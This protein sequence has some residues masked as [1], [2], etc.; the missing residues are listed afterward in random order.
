MLRETLQALEK[1]AIAWRQEIFE[2][3]LDAFLRPK[4]HQKW[5]NAMRSKSMLAG[6]MAAR[7]KTIREEHWGSPKIAPDSLREGKLGI[8]KEYLAK[9]PLGETMRLPFETAKDSGLK[10]VNSAGNHDIKQKD[11]LDIFDILVVPEKDGETRLPITFSCGSIKIK[12]KLPRGTELLCGD[13]I[14]L[15]YEQKNAAMDKMVRDSAESLKFPGP[16]S[17]FIPAIEAHLKKVEADKKVNSQVKSLL[18]W[19]LVSI[20]MF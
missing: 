9:H 11:H 1:T 13:V 3:K 6:Q 10:R 15:A 5:A 14:R 12:V 4:M 18:R 8:T 7:E 19:M 17:L 20:W 16:V 2:K